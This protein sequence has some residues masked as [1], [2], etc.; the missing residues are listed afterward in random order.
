MDKGENM[1]Y[2]FSPKLHFAIIN[3]NIWYKNCKNVRK[4]NGK[5][6][7]VCPFREIIEEVEKNIKLK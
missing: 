7:K 4:R 6:C 3:N 2:V 1:K 5:I